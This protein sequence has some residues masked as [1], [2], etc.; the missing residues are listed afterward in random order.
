MAD[1]LLTVEVE[2]DR[3]VIHADR[4][5]LR[6]LAE[7]LLVLAE[8]TPPGQ[9]EHLHLMTPDWGGSE[10]TATAQ[11]DGRV[12]HHVVLFC[13]DEEDASG[14]DHPSQRGNRGEP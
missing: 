13:W 8:S 14:N 12:L 9:H 2:P 11:G 4:Q 5:G 10:L 7:R 1:Y 3:L 6:F